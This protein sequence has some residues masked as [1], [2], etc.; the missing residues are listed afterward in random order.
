MIFNYVVFGNDNEYYKLAY[1]QLNNRDIC[2]AIYYDDPRFSGL[3]GSIM[4]LLRRIHMSPK[5]NKHFKLPLKSIWNKHLFT[6]P[7][8]DEKP[9]CFVFFSAGR[10]TSHI[11]Y[12][13]IDY[14][15]S[16]YPKSRYVV[17]YQ[18]LISE[19]NRDISLE[20]FKAEMDMVISFDY[21]DCKRYGLVYHPLVYSD[22]SIC[23]GEEV[24]MSDVY[25]CGAT[26]NRM[27][28]IL[29]VYDEL[30]SEGYK[31]DFILITDDK[32]EI[33]EIKKRK[34][35]KHCNAFSYIENLRHVKMTK[36][37]LEIMQ[38]GGTG[39][40][41]RF[42]EAICFNKRIVSNNEY[43]KNA[44]F[45]NPDDIKIIDDLGSVKDAIQPYEV[46]RLRDYIEAIS[47][48]EFI[49]FIDDGFAVSRNQTF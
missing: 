18:D 24:Q 16:K 22:I 32:K 1:S 12:G 48:L 38:K 9:I 7:F 20:K 21:E 49:R 47:P 6:N 28:K 30:S 43:L 8:N 14:L 25:F 26:K 39:Y 10:F 37:L 4:M 36:Y 40:T 17:F 3:F 5:I 15:K 19:N 44:D 46:C 34:G 42:C 29:D 31:C 11:N 27:K 2:S 35:I 33:S 23:D 13:F 45:Y 41:I